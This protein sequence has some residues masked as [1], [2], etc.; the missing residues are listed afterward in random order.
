[1]PNLIEKVLDAI[2]E[3][4]AACS[5]CVLPKSKTWKDFLWVADPC[6]VEGKS[7]LEHGNL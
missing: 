5:L 3:L 6:R 7:M 4:C 2:S 1:M